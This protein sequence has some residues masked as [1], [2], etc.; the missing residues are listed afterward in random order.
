MPLAKKWKSVII[1]DLKMITKWYM[2]NIAYLYLSIRRSR[3]SVE[4]FELWEKLLS[5]SKL[6]GSG[7]GRE[8]LFVFLRS[9]LLFHL[10]FIMYDHGSGSYSYH[11]YYFVVV[12][13]VNRC[14]YR[15]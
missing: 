10:D 13:I 12:I 6:A 7:S 5:R 1:I 15:E 4:I 3:N 2:D 14:H 9:F 8:I 11:C